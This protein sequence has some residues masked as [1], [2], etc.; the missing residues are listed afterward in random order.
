MESDGWTD[1]GEKESNICFRGFKYKVFDKT[2]V[3][4]R[5]KKRRE[6][7]RQIERGENKIPKSEKLCLR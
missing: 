5:I 7:D 2:L 3:Y 1:V 4:S 6:N